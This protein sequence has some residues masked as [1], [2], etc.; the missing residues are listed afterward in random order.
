MLEQSLVS[1]ALLSGSMDFAANQ[2]DAVV[3]DPSVEVADDTPSDVAEDQIPSDTF[4]ESEKDLCNDLN[5]TWDPYS[6]CLYRSDICFWDS[7]DMRCE[8]QGN[9]GPCANL[10]YSTCQSAP[11]CFWDSSDM[12]CEPF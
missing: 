10:P 4:D 8:W 5:Y 1:I 6:A 7:S 2:S 11:G 9:V 3:I 12:R